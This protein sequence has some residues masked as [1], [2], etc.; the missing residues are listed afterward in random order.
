M[1]R[2]LLALGGIVLIGVGL[3][4]A[5]GWGWGSDFENNATLPQ[6]I[7]SVKLAG[8]SGSVKIRTGPGPATVHQQISYHWRGNPGD[9]FY[10]VEGDQLVLGDCGTNC[11]VDFEVVVPAGVPVSGQLDSGGVDIAGVS[12]VD[13]RADSGDARVEDVPGAVKLRLSSGSIDLRD[14]GEVSLTSDSGRVTGNRV[15]GPVDVSAE[16]GSVE[17]TLVQANDVKVHAESGSVE[18]TVPGGPYRVQGDSDSGHR[19]IGVPT[20]GS[21]AH[22]LDLTTESGSVT[23]RAA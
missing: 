2:P 6:T 11:A 10:R 18:L 16:S 8:E 13:V 19:D 17:F 21:A 15:R 1:A 22:T 5:F 23:V 4:T 7:R 20:D 3:A 9:T 14:V 12:S